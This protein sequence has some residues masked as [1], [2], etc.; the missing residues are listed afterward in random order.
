[1]RSKIRLNEQSGRT[2]AEVF[3][4][5]V[6]AQTAEGLSEVTIRNYKLHLH[7]IS[8][9]LDIQQPMKE[10]TNRQ[11]EETIGGYIVEIAEADFTQSP[12]IAAWMRSASFITLSFILRIRFA[13]WFSRFRL[14]TVSLPANFF[15]LTVNF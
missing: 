10:L 9:H 6:F 14:S 12:A 5:F 11:L 8:K 4:D 2:V 3:D 7:S 13:T 15:I 1:M